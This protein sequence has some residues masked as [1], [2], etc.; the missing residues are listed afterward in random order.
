MIYKSNRMYVPTRIRLKAAFFTS[1]GPS[2]VLVSA[3][4]WNRKSRNK[5]N[6]L[7]D[8]FKKN[9]HIKLMALGKTAKKDLIACY[10]IVE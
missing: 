1:S 5:V 6:A 7:K 10:N 8:K 9:W 3:R 4:L 2:F